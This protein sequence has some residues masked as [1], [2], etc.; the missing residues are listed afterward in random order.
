M[1]C[2]P[3]A[4]VAGAVI[5]A[6]SSAAGP[7]RP[8]HAE[9]P[10]AA[11]CETGSARAV[12]Q[13]FYDELL[14]T[15]KDGVRLGFAGRVGRL[16]PAMQRAFTLPGMTRVAA[17]AQWAALSPEQQQRLTEAFSR[18]SVAN[19]A[20]NFKTFDGERFEVQ[21][22]RPTQGGSIV[23]TRLIPGS[24]EPVQLNYLVRTAEG[25]LRILDVFVNGTI[26]ELAARRSE[27]SSVLR[28]DGADGLLKLLEQKTRALAQS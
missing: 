11:A 28:Q 17:G 12:V 25:C 2:F 15:M 18:F 26:S 9:T 10:P 13:G 23:E 14:S 27:F 24:G 6:L 8:A 19:Y 5:A 16:E 1:R 20:A 4:L 21:G 3:P 22:E 7:L